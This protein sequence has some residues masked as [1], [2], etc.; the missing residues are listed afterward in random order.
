MLKR[1]KDVLPL[2]RELT[3][4]VPLQEA[5]LRLQTILRQRL[6]FSAAQVKRLKQCGGILCNGQPAF[7]TRLAQA[8]DCICCRLPQEAPSPHIQPVPGPV[9]IRY[10][11]ADLLVLDNPV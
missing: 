5:G 1:A 11:D 10:E 4:I 6:G 8:G 7:A 2:E 9:C 3:Y